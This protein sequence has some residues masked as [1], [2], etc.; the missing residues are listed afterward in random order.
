MCVFCA[1]ELIIRLS[2]IVSVRVCVCVR[3]CVLVHLR[4]GVCVRV[5]IDEPRS[6]RARVCAS[7]GPGDISSNA[8][9]DI[10]EGFEDLILGCLKSSSVCFLS[11]LQQQSSAGTTP[12]A[13]PIP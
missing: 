7:P 1:W 5:R 13:A 4:V 12:T 8:V 9:A 11:L 10:S 3:M 6:A 2:R